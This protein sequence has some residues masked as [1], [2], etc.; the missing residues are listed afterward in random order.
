[1]EAPVGRPRVRPVIILAAA[2]GMLGL[3]PPQ[4]NASSPGDLDP[5]FGN[6]G[7]ALASG[8]GDGMVSLHSEQHTLVLQPDGKIVVAESYQAPFCQSGG[9]LTTRYLPDGS[10][11]PGFGEGGFA[12]TQVGSCS[13]VEA[14]A[15]AL[16][17]DG[18]IVV[19]GQSDNSVGTAFTLVRYNPDGSLD[20]AFGGSGI[21]QTNLSGFTFG[22]QDLV[23]Q[24]NG[25]IIACGFVRN[26]TT[27]TDDGVLVR[28]LP[29]GERD[30]TFGN[31]GLVETPN[32]GVFW[33]LALQADGKILV[34]ADRG[35]FRFNDD[36]TSDATFGSGGAVVL[37]P[38]G[39]LVE[40]LA[41]QPDQRII[42]GD[43]RLNPDGTL[44]RTFGSGGFAEIP[45]G[46]GDDGNLALDSAGRITMTGRTPSGET[47]PGGCV[48]RLTPNGVPDSTFGNNGVSAIIPRE[49]GPDFWGIAVKPNDDIVAVGIAAA[50]T[51]S[52][53]FLASY[54]GGSADTHTL[55]VTIS[56]SGSSTVTSS[57]AGIAC[58]PTCAASFPTGSQVTLTAS[59]STTFIGWAGDCSGLG[60]CSL[61]MD[62]EHAVLAT[63]AELSVD[64]VVPVQGYSGTQMVDWIATVTDPNPQPQDS[65]SVTVEWGDGRTSDSTS[66]DV[67]LVQQSP[68]TGPPCPHLA[69]GSPFCFDVFGRHTYGDAQMYDAHVLLTKSGGS[70]TTSVP[71][72]INKGL[73]I[74]AKHFWAFA[75]RPTAPIVATFTDIDPFS[76]NATVDWGDGHNSFVQLNSAHIR[77]DQCPNVPVTECFDLQLTHTYRQVGTY[78]T[79]ICVAKVSPGTVTEDCGAATAHVVRLEAIRK[80]YNDAAHA[81]FE[82]QNLSVASA[83]LQDFHSAENAMI[84]AQAAAGKAAAAADILA[85]TGQ[86]PY[87]DARFWDDFV[88]LT[89]NQAKWL[90]RLRDAKALGDEIALTGLKGIVITAVCETNEIGLLTCSVIHALSLA[91]DNLSLPDPIIVSFVPASGSPGTEVTIR[92]IFPLNAEPLQ[93]YFNAQLASFEV[94][95]R[96]AVYYEISATVPPSA[97]T[98]LISVEVQKGV[99]TSFGY[100]SQPF[101]VN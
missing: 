45:D 42:A 24:A 1:M 80:T 22:A 32:V 4:A 72:G 84:S 98:G 28:Y 49:L 15:V 48:V 90:A 52:S 46:C 93:V 51:P 77:N 13:A 56:G 40:G 53:I 79:T 50:L 14:D 31:G 12:F 3:A 86:V 61:S 7:I 10:L 9:F 88:V 35:V 91:S 27:L 5:T 8:P 29:D 65:Y 17:L 25:K 100:S 38:S 82:F 60:S 39:G 20:P 16:Q 23:I 70:A 63:F 92:A 87:R 73:I 89:G 26:S 58:P 55:N 57:P 18:K 85:S 76:W 97:S 66:T 19:A 36:G 6:G 74:N 44:D 71:I 96:A 41:V 30:T 47:R 101:V 94:T 64:P 62:T 33:A 83:L 11:D 54:L 68:E 78:Q 37:F 21:V 99:I 2:L 43:A 59:P 34:G 75:G 95:E 69:E 81:A 67:T